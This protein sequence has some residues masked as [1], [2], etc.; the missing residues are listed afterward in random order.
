MLRHFFHQSRVYFEL[1]HRQA[2]AYLWLLLFII[3]VTCSPI[4]T[5]YYFPTP[6]DEQDIQ[7]VLDSIP[8]NEQVV[9]SD[10]EKKQGLSFRKNI[11][12]MEEE[13]WVKTGLPV[14]M[15]KRIVKYQ[16]KVRRLKRINDLFTIYGMDSARVAQVSPFLKEVSVASKATTFKRKQQEV[17][18]LDI[19]AADSLSLE[20]LPTIGPVL[21]KRI[22]KY[23]SLLNGYVS[24]EQ[25]K[26]I[27]GI[28][29]EALHILKE[30]TTVKTIP[31]VCSLKSADYQKLNG[32]FYLSG[33]DARYIVN[34][35]KLSPTLCWGELKGGLEMKAQEHLYALELYYSC[36]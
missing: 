33:K 12:E 34:R 17:V 18:L 9:A 23:R 15:A 16:T 22:L 32:H 2:K 26:E 28:T 3:V 19:N 5:Y 31:V 36:D 8:L 4:F 29:P 7:L 20:A 1:D 14:Y 13:D 35:L 30:R 27:Y 10:V 21:A 24:K 25:Y 11:H 6:F